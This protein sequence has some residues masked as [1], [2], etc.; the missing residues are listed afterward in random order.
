MLYLALGLNCK[1]SEERSY[2]AVKFSKAAL[3]YVKLPVGKYLVYK[4]SASGE[5]DS[6]TVTRSTLTTSFY[7]N[8][9]N[10]FTAPS[11]YFEE[12]SLQLTLLKG[13]VQSTWF[14]SN[15]MASYSLNT[16]NA[17]LMLTELVNST[18]Y[19][20]SVFNYPPLNPVNLISSLTVGGKNYSDV[21]MGSFEMG[22]D[23]N[24]P[25]YM[26]RTFFWAKG[27]GTIKREII[28]AGGLIKTH[29]LLRHN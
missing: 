8:D 18:F 17:D 23:L 14:Q 27:V 22:A 7:K 2:P 26:K 24:D 13:S 4:D 28:T 15:A 5:L 9:G 16:D 1:K 3:E 12:F 6:V 10:L 19:F 11:H 21:I 25:V 20:P 29:F